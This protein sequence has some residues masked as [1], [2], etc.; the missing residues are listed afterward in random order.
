[1]ASTK[2]SQMP[3]STLISNPQGWDSVSLAK[4]FK[5]AVI[6]RQCELVPRQ[7]P[8]TDVVREL[9]T[10]QLTTQQQHILHHESHNVRQ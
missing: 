2:V 7:K 3:A 6:G 4:L 8:L 1:M 5:D 9:V 10:L